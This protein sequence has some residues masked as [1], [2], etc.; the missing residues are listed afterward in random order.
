MNAV[1][2]QRRAT[3]F[4]SNPISFNEDLLS[5][6]IQKFSNLGLL[7]SVNKGFGIKIT[8]NG[9]E[10]QDIISLDLKK[11]DNTLK[12]SFGPDRV[13]VLSTKN[14]ESLDVFKSR[15]TELST[16]IKQVCGSYN[17]LAF[18]ANVRFQMSLVLCQKSYNLLTKS[19][20]SD[21][22][23]WQIRK[24]NRVPLTTSDKKSEALINL[25]YSLS[26]NDSLINLPN[27]KDSIVIEFDFNTMVGTP[28]IVLDTIED[29]F[30]DYA[31]EQIEEGI[32]NYKAIFESWAQLN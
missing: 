15:V 22:V 26:R 30:W 2:L 21:P 5:I 25:V 3:F 13:D 31:K 18:G 32:S 28:V 7:P 6:Y 23:E 17:R 11:L 27:S 4:V 24:V 16:V 14:D 8:P 29:V 12:V 10:P 20:D 1:I 9:V 19:D